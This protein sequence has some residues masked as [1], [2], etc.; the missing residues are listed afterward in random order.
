[1]QKLPFFWFGLAALIFIGAGYRMVVFST[2]TL[3]VTGAISIVG[4]QAMITI[5]AVLCT[6]LIYMFILK[7][8]THS[9]VGV[10]GFI[11]LALSALAGL[12]YF[13]GGL[14]H[15]RLLEGINDGNQM[16]IYLGAG[17]AASISGYLIFLTALIIA[18]ASY[19]AN[20]LPETYS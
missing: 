4:I 6:G 14:A 1:M 7:T 9:S 10:L 5:L 17:T 11:H 19:H 12:L 20:N 16:A 13:A 15:A 8:P 2:G 3:G 18:I